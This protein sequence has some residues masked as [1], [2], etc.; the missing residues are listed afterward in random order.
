MDTS[1]ARYLKDVTYPATLM[2]AP[3]GEAN[4][5][6]LNEVL[7]NVGFYSGMELDEFVPRVVDFL[8]EGRGYS[9]ESRVP[10]G[11]GETLL[12]WVDSDIPGHCELYAGA[13]VLISRYAGFPTRLVTGY[14]GGDWNGYENY[15]MVR[16]RNAHA[17]CEIF[18]P[19]RGWVRVDPTPGYG[20]EAGSVED[21]LAGGRLRLDRTWTA[22]LDSL[23][24]LWFR[25]V[26]QFDSEDQAFMAEVAKETGLMGLESLKELW[27]KTKTLLKKDWESIAHTGEW[28][29]F[30]RDIVL[31]ALLVCMLLAIGIAFRHRRRQRRFEAI[32]RHRAG[33]LIK[34]RRLR[35]LAGS[36]PVHDL[37]HL[38]RYGPRQLWPEDTKE[39]MKRSV[40]LRG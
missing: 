23:R 37:L 19:R 6:I 38:I 18:V 14:A 27:A 12:R 11:E 22:W 8:Q 31:P 13:F 36:G 34:L 3:E 32:M 7:R 5:R 2:V 30:I 39:R 16:N 29:G 9:L 24:I 35:G 26:I 15:F 25:R 40:A 1:D 33:T 21:A 20:G 28:G 10:D 4:E 17:W